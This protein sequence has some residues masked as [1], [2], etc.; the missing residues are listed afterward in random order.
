MELHSYV[1]RALHN[2]LW[3][4]GVLRY[5]QHQCQ[6]S[7]SGRVFRYERYEV[8][9]NVDNGARL[10]WVHWDRFNGLTLGAV[11]G[12]DMDTMYVARRHVTADGEDGGKTA[13]GMRHLVGKL[14]TKEGMG[15][16]TV[17]KQVRMNDMRS[18]YTFAHAPALPQAIT[19]PYATFTGFGALSQR[20]YRIT[21][22][23][24]PTT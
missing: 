20:I 14:D 3:I 12:G 21:H 5:G 4:P 6:I 1:C 10:S 16:I 15:R 18:R 24:S 23:A 17:I 2:G 9:E 22:I 13:I 7:L 11:A 19:S 8:L